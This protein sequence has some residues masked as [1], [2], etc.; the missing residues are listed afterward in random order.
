MMSKILYITE[1]YVKPRL[2]IGL[3][4]VWATI[5]MNEPN[6]RISDPHWGDIR[7]FSEGNGTK[8]VLKF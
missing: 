4:R 6:I 5:G 8:N 3:M 1:T 2:T 7:A